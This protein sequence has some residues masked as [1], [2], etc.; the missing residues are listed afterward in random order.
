MD[1][2]PAPRPFLSCCQRFR[3]APDKTI[4]RG[5]RCGNNQTRVFGCGHDTIQNWDTEALAALRPLSIR[6]GLIRRYVQPRGGAFR[7]VSLRKAE[8]FEDM[9]F[10]VCNPYCGKCKPPKERPVICENCGALNEL[11]PDEPRI[12]KKCGAMVPERVV[13]EPL[14][15]KVIGEWCANPCKRGEEVPRL[16][17]QKKCIYHTPMRGI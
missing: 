11:A 15:C 14:L 2:P 8:E 10:H 1:Q 9:G 13:P 16:V 4:K 6:V 7:V 12:C 17:S 5:K 3:S